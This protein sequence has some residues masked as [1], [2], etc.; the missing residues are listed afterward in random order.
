MHRYGSTREDFG[1]IAVSNRT[2]AVDNPRAVFR[3]P[4]V[5]DDYLA[6]PMVDDPMCLLDMD[7]PVDGAMAVV[8]TTEERALNL[9]QRPVCVESFG[10]ALPYHNDGLY[11]LEADSVAARRAVEHLFSRTDYTAMDMD[12][13]YPYDGFSIL[14]MIWLEA[15]YA[16]EGGGPD[17]IRKAWSEVD[18][19]L[20]LFGRVPMYTHGGN[21]SEGRATQGFGHVLETI[22]TSRRRPSIS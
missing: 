15:L 3:S 19:Q 18:Q 20:K 11:W 7:A 2:H 1:R 16:E 4:L 14:T 8:V 10:S 22:R 21:L 6:S 5:L 17:L 13:A 12:L 9:A